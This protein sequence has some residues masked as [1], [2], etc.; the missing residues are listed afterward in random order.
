MWAI[1]LNFKCVRVVFVFYV[2][3][4]WPWGMWGLSS[5]TKNQ[6]YNPC[7]GKGSLNHWTTREVPTSIIVLPCS[8]VHFTT[9]D[10][11]FL[12]WLFLWSTCSSVLL[13]YVRSSPKTCLSLLPWLLGKKQYIPPL[14]SPIAAPLSSEVTR[15]NLPSINEL[16]F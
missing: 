13:A 6:T 16:V 7:I 14:T 10:Q 3:V 1:F 15:R 5:L 9:Q 8:L 2:L 11:K 4:F 12:C